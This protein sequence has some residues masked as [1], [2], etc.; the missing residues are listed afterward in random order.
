MKRTL[1]IILVSTSIVFVVGQAFGAGATF[2]LLAPA[3]EMFTSQSRV[4]IIA[5]I[6]GETDAKRVEILD[7]GKTAGYA[8]LKN[9]TMVYVATLSKGKHELVLAASGVRRRSIRVF[10]GKQDDYNYHVKLEP[11]YCET[12]HSQASRGIY[13]GAF[14]QTG[15]C[16][17]CHDPVDRG[18]FVHGPVAVGACTPCHDPHGSR[19]ENYLVTASRQLCLNCHS[20]SVSQ[21]H[22]ENRRNANCVECHDPHS[23][24]EAYLLR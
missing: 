3:E 4:L 8:E 5:V 9:N 11:D 23:S 13:K 17:E 1:I 24:E 15:L 12:C 21:N 22:T 19:N 7:N 6:E 16:A 10:F 20:Q 14:S 18:K 2:K